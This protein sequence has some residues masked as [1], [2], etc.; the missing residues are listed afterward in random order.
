MTLWGVLSGLTSFWKFQTPLL[1]AIFIGPTQ[2]IVGLYL[3]SFHS[4][5]FSVLIIE[6][7][8]LSDIS[9]PFSFWH[10]FL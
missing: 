9:H 3:V 7:M 6:K 4:L 8:R 2:V 10:H 5:L 1:L